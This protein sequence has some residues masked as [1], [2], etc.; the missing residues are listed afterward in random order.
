MVDKGELILKESIQNCIFFLLFKE[1]IMQWALEEVGLQEDLF[2]K[3]KHQPSLA[4]HSIDVKM[5]E[6]SVKFTVAE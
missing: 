3:L 2:S 4:F 1:R 6:E 5:K